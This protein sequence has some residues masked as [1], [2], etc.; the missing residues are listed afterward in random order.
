MIDP[1][2]RKYLAIPEDN[3]AD[4]LF[5]TLPETALENQGVLDW[6]HDNFARGCYVYP[7]NGT[8]ILQI[9]NLG[10]KIL[11]N[12]LLD[13]AIDNFGGTLNGL[14]CI[15]VEVATAVLSAD[16]P[17]DYSPNGQIYGKDGEVLRQKTVEEL[18]LCIRGDKGRALILCVE[19]GVNYPLPDGGTANSGENGDPRGIQMDQVERFR[20]QFPAYYVYSDEQLALWRA[21]NQSV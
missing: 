12:V 20:I 4:Y 8:A 2:I 17:M 18:M 1:R 14:P 19:K 10:R 21:N 11:T 13:A 7:S 9:N 15:A 16:V 6:I 5:I 3:P